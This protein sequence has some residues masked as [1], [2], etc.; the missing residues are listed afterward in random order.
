[1]YVLRRLIGLLINRMCQSGALCGE[2]RVVYSV[3]ENVAELECGVRA[4]CCARR[5][6]QCYRRCVEYKT[7]DALLQGNDRDFKYFYM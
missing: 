1:M 5:E 6:R 7:Q 3:M 4:V 2:R